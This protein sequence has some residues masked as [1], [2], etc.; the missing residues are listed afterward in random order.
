MPRGYFAEHSGDSSSGCGAPSMPSARSPD[1]KFATMSA[2][3]TGLCGD[4]SEKENINPTNAVEAAG[5]DDGLFVDQPCVGGV[6]VVTP[7]LKR[8]RTV[9]GAGDLCGGNDLRAQWM[10]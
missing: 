10:E 2:S 7:P 3:P 9:R 5:A 4:D 8:Q 6:A 1:R